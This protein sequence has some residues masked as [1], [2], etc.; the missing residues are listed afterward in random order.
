MHTVVRH[1]RHV[2]YG[3]NNVQYVYCARAYAVI[4]LFM[5]VVYEVQTKK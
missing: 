3:R 4:S 2:R 1:R 5:K